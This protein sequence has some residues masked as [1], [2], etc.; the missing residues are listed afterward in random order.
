MTVRFFATRLTVPN[1]ALIKWH[2]CG[3]QVSDH[4]RSCPQCGT[5]V[6]ATIKRRQKAV[7]VQSA[8]GFAV[9]SL[10]GVF[11]WFALRRVFHQLSA[12]HQNVEQ[13]QRQRES[14]LPSSRLSPI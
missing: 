2:E 11:V 4:S 8:M 10:V 5:P 13:E 14:A 7:L 12:P 1:M 6:I 3:G 9:A